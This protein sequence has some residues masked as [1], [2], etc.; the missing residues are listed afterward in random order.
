MTGLNAVF[1]LIHCALSRPST[2]PSVRI[3][4][5]LGGIIPRSHGETMCRSRATA[6]FTTGS[7]S[8]T[9]PEEAQCHPASSSLPS[10]KAGPP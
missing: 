1:L 8:P 9:Q 2:L 5:K 4:V 7:K 10:W 3:V 6:D